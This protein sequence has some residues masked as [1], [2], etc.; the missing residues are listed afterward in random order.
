MYQLE[1]REMLKMLQPDYDWSKHH[2][3]ELLEM[4]NWCHH[5]DYWEESI[6]TLRKKVHAR[7]KEILATRE[8]IPTKAE[9]KALRK[10]KANYQKN[11]SYSKN[12]NR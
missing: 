2:T 11:Y 6:N 8:H 12:R 10:E 9:T 7:M 1:E 3:R 5:G 4:K